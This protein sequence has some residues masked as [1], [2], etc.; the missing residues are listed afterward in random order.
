MIMKHALFISLLFSLVSFT[1]MS[2]ETQIQLTEKVSITFPE[3]PEVR[4]MQNIASVYSLK[5]ADSSANFFA[6]VQDL[7]KN[8]GL[9]AD[10]LEAAQSGPEFWL[11]LEA[12]FVAQLGS[13]TQVLSRERKKIGI[14][15]VLILVLS[16]VRNG[17][18]MEVTSYVFISGVHSINLV[19]NKRSDKAS[20]DM[21]NKF[22][23]SL[24]MTE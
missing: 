2:Q 5:L 7:G 16:I 14:H 1:V 23:N 10:Q 4:N 18:K 21:K 6:I 11:E 8:N 17:N 19:Y 20:V 15:D 3:N 12:S 22:F 9:T 24:N 13:E